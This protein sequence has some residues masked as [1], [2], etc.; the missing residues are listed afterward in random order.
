MRVLVTGGAG[1]IGSHTLIELLG[2]AHAVCVLRWITRHKRQARGCSMWGP[3]PATRCTTWSKL[4][5]AIH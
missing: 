3:A 2:Q 1:Y 4:S 5:P